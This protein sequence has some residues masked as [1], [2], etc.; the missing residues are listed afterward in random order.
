MTET[1]SSRGGTIATLAALAAVLA[2]SLS[3]LVVPPLGVPLALLVVWLAV[4]RAP[5][6][7][8]GL[9]RPASWLRELA[10]GAGLAVALQAFAML[11]LVPLLL[12]LGIEPPD[13]SRFDDV[14]GNV[15]ALLVFLAVSWTTAGFGE[16]V[17]W[18]G[19]VLRRVAHLL[20][21]G[22][23]AWAASIAGSAVVFGLLHAY[24]GPF[25]VVMTGFAGL[26]FA[27][28]YKA[29]RC[30]LWPCIFGHALTDTLAFVALWA[31]LLDGAF[32]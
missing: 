27:I 18:R 22:R 19:F 3:D 15:P 17:I 5:L 16:E 11:V 28:L 31:G 12:R 2:V 24:Q 8:L 14:R 13:L 21:D 29:R 23:A 10:I 1:R 4:R 7:R 25:G 6:P 20:G 30:S 26:V 32:G 9:A